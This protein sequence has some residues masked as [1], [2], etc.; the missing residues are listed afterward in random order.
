MATLYTTAKRDV[1][2]DWASG[3]TLKAMLISDAHTP[4]AAHDFVADLT[5]NEIPSTTRQTLA[6]VAVSVSG[7]NAYVSA[8]PITFSAVPDPGGGLKAKYVAVF[9]DAGGSDATKELVAL[10]AFG[11]AQTL[12]GSDVTMNWNPDG[13]FGIST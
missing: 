8:D 1:L 10:V 12:D 11:E 6:N 4:S 7:T 3:K 5:S 13:I 9:D 2:E